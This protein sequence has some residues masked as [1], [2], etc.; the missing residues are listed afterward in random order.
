[1]A[2]A[3]GRISRDKYNVDSQLVDGWEWSHWVL[4]MS[5]IRTQNCWKSRRSRRNNEGYRIEKAVLKDRFKNF[6]A[7]CGIYELK[8]T[9]GGTSLVVYMGCTCRRNAANGFIARLMEYC[10]HGSHK[11]KYLNA[12]L[13]EGYRVYVR[14]KQ[15]CNPRENANEWSKRKAEK[16]EDVVL[17]HIMYPW[18]LRY[19][20][21]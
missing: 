9:K 20:N 5:P 3:K 2:E 17:L 6:P 10:R 18:N 1:M 19:P 15:S 14:Y 4:V 11:K 21:P 16:D 13:K 7:V 8:I 12:A